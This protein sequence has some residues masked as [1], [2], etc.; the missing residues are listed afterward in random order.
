MAVALGS[1]KLS[2][3]PEKKTFGGKQGFNNKKKREFF[4]E[5]TEEKASESKEETKEE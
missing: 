2:Q 3:K 1:S 5:T 4:V